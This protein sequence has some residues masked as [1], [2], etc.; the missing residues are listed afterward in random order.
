MSEI[1]DLTYYQKDRDVILNKAKVFYKNN[2]ERL[3]VKWYVIFVYT[4]SN[5]YNH[6]I[7][8]RLT[9]INA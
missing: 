6:V 4:L 8:D 5:P 2:K 9:E 3:K 1:A 7:L